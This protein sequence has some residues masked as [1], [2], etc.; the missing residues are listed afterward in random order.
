[1]F[2]DHPN[3]PYTSQSYQNQPNTSQ[4]Y[5][6]QPNTSQ[7]YLGKPY[8]TA[9]IP[10]VRS[11]GFLT[12]MFGRGEAT[13]Y[14]ESLLKVN[15]RDLFLF[16]DVLG[17][18]NA[19]MVPNPSINDGRYVAIA[20]NN[21][22][23]WLLDITPGPLYRVVP[24]KIWTPP[25]QSDWRR[26]VEQA[27]LRMPIFFIQN[28]GATGLPLARGLSGQRALLRGGD[29]PAHLGGGHSTQI[30]IAW[31][32]YESWERQIQI[33]DQTRQR[34]EITLE[35]FV[36]LIAGVVDR[37]LRVASSTPVPDTAWRVGPGGI[38]SNDVIL[39]GA[40]QVSAGGWMPILQVFNPSHPTPPPSHYSPVH[41]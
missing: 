22:P 36:K 18:H 32:G 34:N 16:G 35:R 39:V 5:Q 8:A 17:W 40:V 6:N 3:R 13:L 24:Q 30:R 41:A 10:F 20:P 28:D 23:L 4:G 37:F 29:K 33:R 26:Y 14:I 2:S 21:Q 12:K 25:N 11:E 19:L 31:P 27:N 9:V 38:T 1:M 15:A 7:I